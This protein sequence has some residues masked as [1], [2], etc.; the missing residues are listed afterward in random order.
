MQGVAKSLESLRSYV[1]KIEL[2]NESSKT[3]VYEDAKQVLQE[4][5]ENINTCNKI[6]EQRRDKK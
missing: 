6:L 3:S 4:I 5:Y 2:F 1:T